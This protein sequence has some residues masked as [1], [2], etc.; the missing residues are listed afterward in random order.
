MDLSKV[1]NVPL[2]ASPIKVRMKAMGNA[3]Q[4]EL[5]KSDS[6]EVRLLLFHPG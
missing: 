3:D 5:V 1:N 2:E 4:E 6:N